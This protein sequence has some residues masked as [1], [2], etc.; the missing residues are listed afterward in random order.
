MMLRVV[1]GAIT[2][3]GRRPSLDIQ[4]KACGEEDEP[5]TDRQVGS[6]AL[7]IQP[8]VTRRGVAQASL[9]KVMAREMLYVKET[10]LYL[11]RL[12]GVV[13]TP[14]ISHQTVPR[15]PS[16]RDSSDGSGVE[17]S[18]LRDGSGS[19]ASHPPSLSMRRS[20]T[21]CSDIYG[22]NDGLK[23]STNDSFRQRLTQR[24]GLW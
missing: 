10:I 2:G 15:H 13:T 3:G 19:S 9:A 23:T 18:R 20:W 12:G 14:A 24:P 11:K 21:R 17:A 5:G 8:S 22:P 16:D 1:G 6:T 7:R 4:G